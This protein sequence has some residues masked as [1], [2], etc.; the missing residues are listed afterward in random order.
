MILRDRKRFIG[1]WLSLG[2]VSAVFICGCATQQEVMDLK[3]H[4]NKA[5]LQVSELSNQVY[6]LET[7]LKRLESRESQIPDHVRRLADLEAKLNSLQEETRS[8]ITA[9]QENMNLWRKFDQKFQDLSREIENERIRSLQ[10]QEEIRKKIEELSHQS[11]SGLSSEGEDLENMASQPGPLQSPSDY[12]PSGTPTS[13]V[14]SNDRAPINPSE[15][16]G[17]IDERGMYEEAH[18]A[19][20]QQDWARAQSKFSAFLDRFPKSD[21]ADNAQFWIAESFFNQKKYEKAILEYEKVIQNYPKGDK[22]ISAL[23]KQALSF[24]AI[25]KTKEASIL[26]KQVIKKA[27]KSEQAKIAQ[28]K[29]DSI[30]K[31]GEN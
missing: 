15:K 31:K 26:F 4:V 18:Q 14:S 20:V 5:I 1:Y 11:G 28:K 22:L 17:Q 27:P 8:H 21:L 30:E 16:P 12:P 24:Q 13:E 25:G 19:F 23:L 3:P 7:R 9:E 6:D 10:F 29:L 2:V